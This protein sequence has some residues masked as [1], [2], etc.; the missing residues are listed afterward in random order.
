MYL[1]F[2]SKCGNFTDWFYILLKPRAQFVHFLVTNE[3]HTFP[4]SGLYGIIN[5]GHGS[6]G[7]R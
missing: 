4:D 5:V 1:L 3:A 6:T 7:Q 2:N